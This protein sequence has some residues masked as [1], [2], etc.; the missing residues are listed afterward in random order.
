MKKIL[1]N[2]NN[3]KS[4]ITIIC[5]FSFKILET[6]FTGRKPPD[7]IRV[8]ARFKELKYLIEKMFKITKIKR[9]NKEYKMKI[10]NPCL[11]IS[12][13]LNEI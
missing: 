9:V 7:E 4:E 3:I 11:K 12:E 10:L 1:K 13:L 8:K 6:S 5:E 2:D